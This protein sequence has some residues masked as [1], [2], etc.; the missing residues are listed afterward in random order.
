MTEEMYEP[1]SDH[2]EQAKNRE[3]WQYKGKPNR[4]ALTEIHVGRI[5]VLED[6]N[7]RLLSEQSLSNSA[8]V[9]LDLFGTDYDVFREGRGDEDFRVAIQTKLN[10]LRSSGQVNILLFNLQRLAGGRQVS[11]RQVFPLTLLMWIF[12][13]DFGDI[14][15]AEAARI[16]AA[17][18]EIKAAG[19]GLEIG[20]QLNATAFIIS[21]N[22]SGGP[23]GQGVATLIDGSDGGAF[24]KSVTDM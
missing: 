10:L 13:D 23:A 22:P 6:I 11:L 4:D 1:I 2:V 8:G 20:L 18:Q 21:D 9:Q 16:D 15:G 5:Q 24:V 3:V 19:V 12:V 7:S 17:M 14:T